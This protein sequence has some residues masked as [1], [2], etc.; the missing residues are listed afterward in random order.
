[1]AESTSTSES[2][3]V[4]VV[5]DSPSTR[6][7]LR[8]VLE[9]HGLQVVEA[10]DGAECLEQ[11]EAQPPDLILLDVMMPKLGGLETCRRLRANFGLDQLPVIMVTTRATEEECVDGLG[12]G[13][14]DYIYKPFDRSTL[15]ARVRTQLALQQGRRREREL[16]RQLREH[17]RMETGR[18]FCAGVAHNF[19]NILGSIQGAVDL[20]A[21]ESAGS[22]RAQR[23]VALIQGAVQQGA[24]FTK[25]MVGIETA[26]ESRSDPLAE[27][28][29]GIGEIQRA[30]DG[31][32]VAI[33]WHLESGL[34]RV[35]LST[36]AVREVLTN[37]VLNAI[38]AIDGAGA[39]RIEATACKDGRMVQ[40]VV[41]DTGRG[42][43]NETVKKLF[44]PFFSTK[45]VDQEHAVSIDGRGFGLF[46]VH[47]L[48]KA[49]GGSVSVASTPGKGTTVTLEFRAA[50]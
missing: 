1:M 16:H 50:L 46:R 40:V 13:A 44:Q 30:L 12:A 8:G 23:C 10:Q 25:R 33:T 27:I 11:C 32:R 19:N 4:L 21:K 26:G 29:S 7:M 28:V 42:M 5:D 49:A 41:S 17:D 18:L 24:K 35:Q 3:R 6:M 14:N 39:V 38:E 34:R 48:M 47:N 15:L 22:A 20:L 2:A 37:V 36:N 9:E 31:D 45:Q 43:D